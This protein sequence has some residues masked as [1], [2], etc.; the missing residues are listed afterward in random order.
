MVQ[1]PSCGYPVEGIIIAE[2][3]ASSFVESKVASIITIDIESTSLKIQTD[4]FEIY[5]EDVILNILPQM[6]S[7][8][9]QSIK[10][11]NVSI[12]FSAEAP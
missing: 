9:N 10:G 7:V 11:I 6:S 4:D 2:V 12:T 5:E 8:S 1:N 3:R